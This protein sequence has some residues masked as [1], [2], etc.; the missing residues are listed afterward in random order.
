MK[1]YQKDALASI[2]I[3]TSNYRINKGEEGRDTW[4]S[5]LLLVKDYGKD[6]QA[7]VGA[8]EQYYVED[9]GGF[10]AY[11]SKPTATKKPKRLGRFRTQREAIA[12]IVSYHLG[13]PSRIPTV[14]RRRF[15]PVAKLTFPD[16]EEA[17]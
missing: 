7:E 10:Y 3:T 16:K 12:S 4:V 14:E 1:K 11:T 17:A 9:R 5:G 13:V 6:T 8:I 2:G 15:R